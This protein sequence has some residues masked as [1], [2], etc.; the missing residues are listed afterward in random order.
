MS[1][2][3]KYHKAYQD[4]HRDRIN[5]R[6]RK[7]S[8]FRKYGIPMERYE[9]LYPEFKENKKYYLRLKELNPETVQLLLSKFHADHAKKFSLQFVS[10]ILK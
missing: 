1:S 9:E 3:T 10:Q 5:L 7:Q 4:K 6:H 2:Y 8:C